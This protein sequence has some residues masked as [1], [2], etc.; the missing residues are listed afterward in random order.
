VERCVC[1]WVKK[2]E[3]EEPQVIFCNELWCVRV[4]GAGEKRIQ[5]EGRVGCGCVDV[6]TRIEEEMRRAAHVRACIDEYLTI[7]RAVHGGSISAIY[8]ECVHTSM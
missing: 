3:R 4:C 8:L 2:R 6:W 5:G 1:V 7:S